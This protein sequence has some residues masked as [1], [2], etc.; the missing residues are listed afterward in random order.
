M[1]SDLLHST[2]CFIGSVPFC[3]FP[4]LTTQRG[5]LLSREK[6]KKSEGDGGEEHLL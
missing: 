1:T 5:H 4:D 2:V 6:M 3:T